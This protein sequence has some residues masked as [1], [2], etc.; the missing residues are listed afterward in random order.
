[1]R[2]CTILFP[3][4]VPL[5]F[6]ACSARKSIGDELNEDGTATGGT[7]P[8]D[9]SDDDGTSGSTGEETHQVDYTVNKDVDVLFVIDNAGTMGEEQETL[10]HSLA[11]FIEVLEQE[12][13]KANYRIG[14][15]TTDNGNPWCS[16]TTP[17]AG[18]LRASSCLSRLDEFT[19][20]GT[21]PATVK[22]SACTDIC[23]HDTI[24]I[25]PTTTEEDDVP[26]PRPWLE[27]IEGS[28]NLP[29]GVSTT[30]A[31]QCF[32]PQGINGCMFKSHLES[33]YRALERM[34]DSKEASHGFLRKDALLAVIIVTDGA[35]C[36]YR[37]E[38][39][40][41]FWPEGDRVF[42]SNPYD[43]YP[44]L[45]VCWNAGVACTGGPGTYDE[46]HAQDK[47]EDGDAT[48]PANAVLHPVSRY[49]DLLQGIEDDKKARN[50]EQEV[51]VSV[52]SG[53]PEGY[54]DGQ[55]LVYEDADDPVFQH[56]YGIGPGCESVFSVALPP[57]RLREFA[58]AFEVDG[59]RN[60]FSTCSTSYAD[61]LE[62]IAERIADQVK[63]ACMPVCV[64][65]AEPGTAGLQPDCTMEETAPSAD[66]PVQR[67]VPAC[68]V[69][70]DEGTWDLPSASD[71]VCFRAL[72]ENDTPTDL[73]DISE[74][75]LDS[76]WNV[77]FVIER[78]PGFP[79]PG[80]THVDATCKVS[81]T[82]E[83]DC[84]DL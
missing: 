16:G 58:E 12:N 5:V 50:P 74:D 56:D 54:A 77:E 47:A 52:V 17:E 43:D 8:G 72:T 38:H 35:D 6:Y 83:Q 19:F 3:L 11:P 7:E 71:N 49:I 75:C 14:I 39:E 61:A 48:D 76:G 81:Q 40:S 70:L 13:V 46:C 21:E 1:M 2:P 60:L 27:N 62:Q 4:L 32:A 78:R 57:V 30:E 36:S 26:R 66:G 25:S 68:A 41:I 73:D 69:D 24:A 10:A 37:P 51:L 9:G 59:E 29:A 28:T 44:S 64:A 67:S 23:S 82:P 65:D 34:E 33:M 53:V 31:F 80:G 84:P 18:E 63:P 42:W 20:I 45:A 15:T 79:P 55:E 22:E